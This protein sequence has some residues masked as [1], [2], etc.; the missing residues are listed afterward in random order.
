MLKD[1]ILLELENNRSEYISGQMLAGR[2]GVSR[3]AVWKAINTLKKEGYQIDSVTN[4]GYVLR[5][6]SDVLSLAGIK[7]RMGDS[8]VHII[9]QESLDSTNNEAKRLL[10]TDCDL[11]HTLI[12]CN[13]QI[14]GRGRNGNS[15]NSPADSGVYMTLVY[16]LIRPVNSPEYA[17]KI[18]AQAVARAVSDLC[19][20]ELT[21]NES[22]G[23]YY[24]G[25]K[26]GGILIEAVTGLESGYIGHIITGIGI[27]PEHF[28]VSRNDLIAAITGRLMSVYSSDED[29]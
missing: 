15:F 5:D 1:S 22:G 26:I 24:G 25:S 18:T 14:K 13:E 6:D 4:R 2:Y 29:F 19:G 28:T 23:I 9:V 20:I 27:V 7:A 21:I 3:N 16:K 10:A 17:N 12:V 11:E 8:C